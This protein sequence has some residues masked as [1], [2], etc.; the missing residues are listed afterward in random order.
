MPH[1]EHPDDLVV[2]VKSAW[3][4]FKEFA[5]RDNVV[6]V[7]VGLIVANAF[8]A[9]VTSMVSDVLLPP[10]ALLPFMNRNIEEKFVV[11]RGGPHYNRTILTG[12]NT[13]QQASDDGAV[14]MA[15]GLFIMH[16]VRFFFIALTLYAVA[17]I[18]SAVSHENIIN[19][20]Q[21]CVYCRKPIS[22]SAKRC[23]FC[24]S[25]QDGRDDIKPNNPADNTVN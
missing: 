22:L 18:Y 4:G 17:Q 24:T 10:L 2:G 16:L 3:Q 21:K 11:L 1:W 12:Y 9:V 8:T 7:A 14:T 5:L 20:T 23:A 25:W 19:K 13:L 6:E 15:Y